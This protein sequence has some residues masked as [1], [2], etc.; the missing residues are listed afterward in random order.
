MTNLSELD[1]SD[2]SMSANIFK[3]VDR[4]TFVISTYSVS[5]ILS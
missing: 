3:Q 1:V 4:S 2:T 5:N